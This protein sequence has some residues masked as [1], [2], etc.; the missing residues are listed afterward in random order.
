M[1]DSIKFFIGVVSWESPSEMTICMRPMSFPKM[2][3]RA[4]R[5]SQRKIQPCSLGTKHLK[6]VQISL[7]DV[8]LVKVKKG[9][10]LEFVLNVTSSF[11]TCGNLRKRLR[12]VAVIHTTAKNMSRSS[13]TCR[14]ERC[15]VTQAFIRTCSLVESEEGNCAAVPRVDEATKFEVC[16]PGLACDVPFKESTM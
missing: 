2:V 1:S 9:I 16:T 12:S 5:R 11:T 15:F 13:A 4:V 7:S 3:G 10:P 14:D 8:F 6:M